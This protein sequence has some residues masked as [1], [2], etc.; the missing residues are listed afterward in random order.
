MSFIFSISPGELV[1]AL[2][3]SLSPGEPGNNN[4]DNNNNNNNNNNN[5][6]L[7]CAHQRPERSHRTC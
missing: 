7:S 3:F 1:W 2:F 4:N 5:V 6:H